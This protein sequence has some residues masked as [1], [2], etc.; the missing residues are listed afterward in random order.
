[1]YLQH[2]NLD[3]LPFTLT[4]NTG[5]YCD[6]VGHQEALNV[7]LISLRSGEG[8][9]KVTGEVGSGKTLLCRKLLT[10]L[11]DDFVTAYIPSPDP[12]LASEGLQRILALELGVVIDAQADKRSCLE[13]LTQRLLVLHGQKKKVV[14]LVDEAQILTDQCLEAIRL[15]TN[16]ETES[17]KLLQVVLFAQPELNVRLQQAALRQLEQ[18]ITFSCQLSPIVEADLEHYV[19]RR[20]AVAGYTQ[21]Q[22]FTPRA[23]HLLYRKSGGI[24]R[25]INILCHKALLV[26]YGRGIQ[27]I[28]W[29]CI[30]KASRDTQRSMAGS[31]WSQH[32]MVFI[33]WVLVGLA[34]TSVVIRYKQWHDVSAHS[35]KTVTEE[36]R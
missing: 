16:L 10:M 1:M 33:L 2:F 32:K 3:K 15:L 26:A 28:T 19:M 17:E 25:L 36:L 13:Q 20:L 12:N 14:L 30:H 27:Q 35:T 29:R 23:L 21:Q 11:G 31:A 34:A 24:P 4:P 6:L 7:L 18:R 9:I 8:F 22:L 5:F